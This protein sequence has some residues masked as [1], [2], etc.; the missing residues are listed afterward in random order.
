M[1]ASPWPLAIALS[2]NARCFPSAENVGIIAPAG[3][4]EFAII[5]PLSVS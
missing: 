1:S 2:V 3:T 4:P 5:M